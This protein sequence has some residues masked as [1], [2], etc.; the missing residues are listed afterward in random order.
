[1][2]CKNCGIVGVDL[3][4]CSG[5]KEVAY[6]SKICQKDDWRKSHKESCIKFI[7]QVSILKE[8]VEKKQ[9]SSVSEE[10]ANCGVQ[11]ALLASC[12]RCKITRYCC[13]AC[14]RQDW[15]AVG[16]HKKFCI[17]T[18]ERLPGA[19]GDSNLIDGIKCMI[20]QEL[21]SVRSQS[22]LAY[23]HV[24][25]SDCLADLQE[26]VNAQKR[27]PV[28]RSTLDIKSA[29]ESTKETELPTDLFAEARNAYHS[30]D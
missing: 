22:T 21:L 5:C 13:Q 4:Q 18:T 11:A 3:K 20:C 27:C 17:P 25:H 15:I 2:V 30:K 14:Q 23:S 19:L 16:G 7:P 24:F 10:C 6:C 28:C 29:K 8:S 26:S 12:S 9:P 1:M